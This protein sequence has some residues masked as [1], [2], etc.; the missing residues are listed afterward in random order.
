MAATGVVVT[1]PAIEYSQLAGYLPLVSYLGWDLGLETPYAAGE[2]LPC[3]L[4]ME[5]AQATA[6]W[7]YVV[8]ALLD[9]D[10]GQ[11]ITGTGFGVLWDDGAGCGY[12]SGDY[13]SAF[14]VDAASYITVPCMF[15]LGQSNA[16]LALAM[17]QMQG[18]E[19]AADDPVRGQV[20]TL[21]TQ[22]A[23]TDMGTLIVPLAMVMM[24]GV[25]MPMISREF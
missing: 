24:M 5:N 19:P 6:E 18:S 22:A 10:T 15:T 3:T 13:L 9:A 1:H 12:N 23:G 25:M 4:H 17:C 14:Q 7:L 2:V 16:Y 21:L 8:G 11:V 20:S